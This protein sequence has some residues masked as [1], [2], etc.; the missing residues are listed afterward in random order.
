MSNFEK[1]LE[2][3]QNQVY[4]MNYKSSVIQKAKDFLNTTIGNL[5]GWKLTIVDSSGKDNP[6]VVPFDGEAL[7]NAKIGDTIL[8]SKDLDD[9]KAGK[10]INPNEIENIDYDQRIIKIKRNVRARM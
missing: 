10:V 4:M 2:A 8:T 9:V 1:Y 7:R 6:I 3:A 5:K